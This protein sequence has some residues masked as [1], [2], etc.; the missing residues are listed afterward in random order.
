MNPSR[1]CIIFY[2]HIGEYGGIERNIIA[3]AIEIRRRGM[4]PVLVCFYDHVGMER[5]EGNLEVVQLGDSRNPWSKAAK[6]SKALAD[7]ID[8]IKGLPLFFGGKA[9]FY[10][11]LDRKIPYVL[12]FTDPPSLLSAGPKLTGIRAVLTTIRERLANRVMTAGVKRARVRLTM[13]QWNAEELQS[14]YGEPFDVIY[15]GGLLPS[16]DLNSKP[17]CR[18]KVLRL[19]SICRI[20]GSKNLDWILDA[21]VAIK[22]SE[23]AQCFDKLEVII[24]GKGPDLERLQKRAAELGVESTV[25][26]PGFMDPLQVEDAFRSADLFLVPARQGFGLPVLEA[27]YRKLPVVLNRESRISEILEQQPWA[28]VSADSSGDFSK[29]VIDHI[30]R[31]R[32]SNPPLSALDQLPSESAWAA[33]IGNRCGWW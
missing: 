16:G 11:G 25:T 12:H 10:G 4:T 1:R 18:G 7:E 22:K 5:Y 24:A 19:F 17:R 31:L 27:L 32:D 3:L 23:V 26:F 6:I 2:P 8:K 21:V 30:I 20:S 13:T 33:Q 9:G 28:S 15:Q 14:C 29:A